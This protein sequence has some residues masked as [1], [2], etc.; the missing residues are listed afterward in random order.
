MRVACSR[1]G[2]PAR[3]PLGA[4]VVERPVGSGGGRTRSTDASCAGSG[5]PRKRREEAQHE[6]AG[7]PC[8]AAQRRKRPAV[9][10]RRAR[11]MLASL[12]V[13]AWVVGPRDPYTGGHLWRV[14]RYAAL[15]C[16]RAGI[17]TEGMRAHRHRRLPARPRQGASPTPSCASARSSACRVRRHQDA[18]TWARA[19]SPGIRS[20]ASCSTRC[21]CTAENARWAHTQRP[22]G[23]DVPAGP[24]RIIRA[25]R[26][27][28]CDDQHKALPGRHA[29]WTPRSK[30]RRVG[31]S[32]PRWPARFVELGRAGLLAH[33][34][35]HSAT[36]S[37]C[38]T[39]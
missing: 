5:R 7:I 36:A 30:P 32:T 35:G 25:V 23:S 4:L 22:V 13:M 14:S 33:I 6:M 19:C 9:G 21:C 38:R 10:T 11:R 17:R 8:A 27:L 34:A 18:L 28:R 31:S 3:C 26:R 16:E 12:L 29:D 15:L 39:A 37:R 24:A 2:R 1:H 20:P